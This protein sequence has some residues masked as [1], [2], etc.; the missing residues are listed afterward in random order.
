MHLV[1]QPGVELDRGDEA[2]DLQQTRADLVVLASTDSELSGLARA[3]ASLGRRLSSLRLA[4]LCTLKHPYSV[5]L[6]VE[7]VITHAKVVLV[8][9]LGGEA[10]WP[11]GLQQVIASCRGTGAHL[12]LIPGCDAPDEALVSQSTRPEDEIKALWR[13]LLEGGAENHKRVLLALDALRHGRALP[14]LEAKSLPSVGVWRSGFTGLLPLE[15]GFRGESSSRVALVFYRALLVSDDLEPVRAL[16]SA[17]EARG[18]TPVPICVTSLKKAEVFD[19]LRSVLKPG[20][21][22][23]IINLTAFAV[24]EGAPLDGAEVPV[25]QAIMA[26][27]ARKVW[28][29][30]PKGLTPRELAMYVALGEVDGRVSGRVIAFK[31]ESSFDEDVQIGLRSHEPDGA[32]IEGLVDKVAALAHLRSTP[33]RARRVGIVLAK[34]PGNEG[35]LAHA[36]GLDVPASLSAILDAM[37]GAGY[38][39]GSGSWEAQALFRTLAEVDRCGG[40]WLERGRCR[41]LLSRLPESLVAA[42]RAAWGPLEQDRLFDADRDALRL[43]IFRCGR[44]ILAIQVARAEG[45]TLETYHDPVT[46]APFS[47]LLFY[48]YLR[49]ELKVDA[50]VHL[51]K[52]GT[53]EWL[54]GKALGLSDSCAPEALIGPVPNFY[55]FILNDPGEG[56]QAKRRTSAVVIDHLTPPLRRGDTYG[57]LWQLERLVDEY[58]ESLLGDPRR[59]DRL[60]ASIVSLTRVLGL[61]RDLK[62]GPADGLEAERLLPAID[63]YLCRVKSR[64]IRDGLHRF[65]ASPC[66][67]ARARLLLAMLS[68]ARGPSVSES[69]ILDAICDD[70][71]VTD[72]VPTQAEPSQSWSGDLPRRLRSHAQKTPRTMADLC[73]VVEA[74]ALALINGTEPAGGLVRTSEVL[75]ALHADIAPRLDGSGPMEMG[76]LLRGLDGRFVPP[77]PAGSPTRGQDRVLPSGRNFYAFDNRLLPTR[78]AFALGHESAERLV[79]LYRQDHGAWPR[80]IAMNAWGTANLRTGGDDVAMVLALIGARPIWD[81]QTQRVH[82]FEVIA[83]EQL[84]RPRCDFVL[85][86]SGFFRDSFAEQ[87]ELMNRAAAAISELSEPLEANPLTAA[88]GTARIFSNASGDFGGGIKALTLG[89]Q[90][91]ERAELGQRFLER[92]AYAQGT[93][94]GA[95]SDVGAFREGL[96]RADL[97]TQV[98]DSREF[99]LL[100]S[101]DFFEFEGGLAAAVEASGGKAHL[102]HGDT[103]RPGAPSFLAL[104]EELSL[105]VR[106]RATHPRWVGRMKTHGAR[107]AWE[108]TRPVHALFGYAATTDAAPSSLFDALFETYVSDQETADFI[109]QNNRSAFEAMMARFAQARARGFWKSQSNAAVRLLDELSGPDGERRAG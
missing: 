87:I 100:D 90:W 60:F 106:G 92:G 55:P 78:A 69:S 66:G 63:A 25:I 101:D 41:A 105:V 49:F 32:A 14:S 20:R 8:R 13:L 96:Q 50:L 46:P 62:L 38:D 47:Y 11:Y 103:S 42:S 40:E 80:V 72:C 81:E 95:K 73:E 77:G 65:G 18:L 94:F 26:T 23:A 36:V 109:A 107:G 48:L 21:L 93:G 56:C 33:P 71:G 24:G 82:A 39:L 53:L 108:L 74:F 67:E 31:G 85:R 57:R 22:C 43:P 61:D 29:E 1:L 27:R 10:Y 45:E 4:N 3:K 84:G 37:S 34:F 98:Q 89:N 9:P 99:D 35:S 76:N 15:A 19:A 70:L 17:L 6:Y 88:V 5:D 97:V 58:A 75:H 79:A 16:V 51:G 68:V 91:Q 104:H 83:L 54:P 102:Y 59:L 64:Q 86:V 30:D 28:E 12:L 2:V 44:V 7:K 52:H